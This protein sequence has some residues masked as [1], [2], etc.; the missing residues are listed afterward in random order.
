MEV[1]KWPSAIG[2]LAKQQRKQTKKTT[3]QN[4]TFMPYG[5]KMQASF[6][7]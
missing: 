3:K 1:G 7:R 5:R 4:K 6:M 2:N